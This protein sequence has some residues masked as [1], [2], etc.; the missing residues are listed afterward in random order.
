MIRKTKI[1]KKDYLIDIID[2][3]DYLQEF[4]SGAMKNVVL[5]NPELDGT[6]NQ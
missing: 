3:N 1:S 4:S 6:L 2:E 5:K